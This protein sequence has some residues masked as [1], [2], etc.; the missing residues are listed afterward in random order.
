MFVVWLH[1]NFAGSG[2]VREM[3][4]YSLVPVPDARRRAFLSNISA[5]GRLRRPRARP[6]RVGE[7]LMVRV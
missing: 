5:S 7:D 1:A 2:Y 3:F 6:L 4:A